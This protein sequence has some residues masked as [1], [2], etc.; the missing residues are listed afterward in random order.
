[1]QLKIRLIR[2]LSEHKANVFIFLYCVKFIRI[3]IYDKFSLL[4]FI[5]RNLFWPSSPSC[6]PTCLSSLLTCTRCNFQRV[7]STPKVFWWQNNTNLLE[8]IQTPW[9]LQCAGGVYLKRFLCDLMY[10]YLMYPMGRVG[11]VEEIFKKLKI[12]LDC[13]IPSDF[14]TNNSYSHL[15]LLKFSTVVLYNFYEGNSLREPL[16][17]NRT[18]RNTRYFINCSM[19]YNFQHISNAMKQSY[20]SLLSQVK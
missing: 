7:E 6:S 16:G 2:T 10:P 15:Y 3:R 17:H 12:I 19:E 5:W 1:V 9:D 18:A 11:L 20:W 14:L 4:S 8:L 13:K